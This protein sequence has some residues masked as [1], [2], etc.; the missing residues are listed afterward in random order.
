MNQ[1]ANNDEFNG[2]KTFET[3]A[4]KEI[5]KIIFTENLWSII[6]AA[7]LPLTIIFSIACLVPIIKLLSISEN[8]Y[9]ILSTTIMVVGYAAAIYFLIKSLRKVNPFKYEVAETIFEKHYNLTA[10]SPLSILGS[11]PLNGDKNLWLY[12]VERLGQIKIKPRIYFP[13]LIAADKLLLTA[14]SLVFMIV[15]IDYKH[16]LPV[17]KPDFAV[18]FGGAPKSINAWVV[19]KDNQGAIIPLEAKDNEIKDGS[20]IEIEVNGAKFAPKI[21]IGGITKKLDKVTDGKFQTRIILHNSGTLKL[22]YFGTRKKWNIE[23]IRPPV[24]RFKGKVDFNPVGTTSIAAHFTINDKNAVSRAQLVLK[25]KVDGNELLSTHEINIKDINSGENNII[26]PTAESP[27]VGYDA[28]AW[29]E[30]ANSDDKTARSQIKLI[31]VPLPVFSNDFSRAIAE[32]RLMI[33]RETHPYKSV[34]F[35]FA[36]I[37]GDN[38]DASDYLSAAPKNIKKAYALLNGIN[39]AKNLE[40]P[41]SY[42]NGISYALASLDGARSTTEAHKTASILWEILQQSIAD[43]Q[44]TKSK[45]SDAIQKL[46]QAIQNGASQEELSQL[47]QELNNA[48]AQHIAEL[49]QQQGDSGDMEVEDK[50]NLSGDNLQKMM[51]DIEE[52]AKNGNSDDALSQLDQL[53]ELMQNLSVSK[54]SGGE[55]NANPSDLVN[56]QRDL[57]DDT[58]NAASANGKNPK[59]NEELAQKQKA[60]E[61]NLEMLKQGKNDDALNAAQQNMK[62]AEQALKNGDLQGALKEQAQALQNLKQSADQ[63]QDNSDNKDPLGRATD[64]NNRGNSENGKGEK[65]KIPPNQDKNRVRDI[66]KTLREKLSNP[67]N[68]SDERDYYENLLK[69][70]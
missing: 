11:R 34:L 68:D 23:I 20:E 5:N 27:L 59:S 52:N 4:R 38:I 9:S 7:L 3:L 66:I 51:D 49:S 26:I 69:K 44:D 10:L 53:D 1:I 16:S 28:Q 15:G 8:L 48:I 30:I 25:G 41:V 33:L 19:A 50:S 65:T 6:R 55:E 63:N 35:N 61:Q 31:N 22:N 37:N 13:R 56:Q 14:F 36:N 40:L 57:M 43:S 45:V 12:E 39:N 32:I 29:I 46:K 17:L 64:D 67:D 24:P 42:L 47:R 2:V 58:N 54:Q 18:Y 60:L 21:T 62:N 70:K